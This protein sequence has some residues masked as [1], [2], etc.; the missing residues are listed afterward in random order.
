MITFDKM[1]ERVAGNMKGGA[2]G[3]GAFMQILVMFLQEILPKLMEN[4]AQTAKGVVAKAKSPGRWG[5]IWMKR[6]SRAVFGRR[7]H[8][9]FGAEIIDATL[10][11]VKKT[12]P[13][14]IDALYEQVS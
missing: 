10:K 3:G 12:K 9:E 5:K 4:C 7:A 11:T 1:A 6:Q 2:A 8:K 14:E 13:A